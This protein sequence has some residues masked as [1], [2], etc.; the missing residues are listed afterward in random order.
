MAQK[1]PENLTKEELY[2]E[3]EEIRS[4]VKG[5]SKFRTRTQEDIFKLLEEAL[6]C[7]EKEASESSLNRAA[8]KVAM[9]RCRKVQA[10]DQDIR[11]SIGIC[12]WGIVALTFSVYAIAK[13]QLWP[14]AGDMAFK[15]ILLGSVV[16]GAARGKP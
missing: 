14:Q 5:M 2:G 13:W 9:A 16:W 15:L 10:E 8:F 1:S 7:V 11:L 3:I 6:D 12:V 4:E